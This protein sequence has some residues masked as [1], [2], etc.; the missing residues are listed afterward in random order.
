MKTNLS[1]AGRLT[2]AGALVAT[3]CLGLASSA[4]ARPDYLKAFKAKYPD[5]ATMQGANCTICHPG[6]EKKVRNDYGKA[7]GGALGAAKVKD[8]E[9]INAALD[10]AAAKPSAVEGKTFGDLIKDGKL[11]NAK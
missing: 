11:P 8:V 1:T 4:D 9:K 2:F 6:K 5:L 10:A 7:V 3:L